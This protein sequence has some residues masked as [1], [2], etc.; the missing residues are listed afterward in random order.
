[1]YLETRREWMRRRRRRMLIRRLIAVAGIVA[2]IL[3]AIPVIN[4]LSG[5][6]VVRLVSEQS[7]KERPEGILALQE[8]T[9]AAE[10]VQAVE[11]STE[12]PTEPPTEPATNPALNEK[13]MLILVNKDNPI[14]A[15]YVIP[16]FTELRNDNRVDSRIYPSLQKMFDDAREEGVLPYITSSFRTMEKQQELM[17]EK[18]ADYEAEG[19]SHEDAARLAKTWVAVP[20]T[21]E[22]QLG[23]SVDIS[24]ADK[25]V[26]EPEVVWKWLNENCWKYGFVQRYPEDKTDITGI[27]D[28]PWHYRYVGEAAAKEMTERG[29]VLEEYLG[30]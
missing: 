4:R 25:S 19:K 27:I 30:R 6:D 13:W 22:H 23:L 8:S 7:K 5:H 28:E 21:S 24:S 18:I 26:Q 15:D 9:A 3:I 14:P 16:E 2:A 17:D 20:G 29:L 1:M 11:T 12:A 10:S